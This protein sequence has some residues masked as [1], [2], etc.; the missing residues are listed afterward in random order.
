M[1]LTNSFHHTSIETRKTLDELSRIEEAIGTSRATAA[2]KRYRRRIWK[3][4]CGISTCVC[5][6][7][8]GRR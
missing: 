3:A 5:G 1:R 8:F 2:E 4:L 6:D 7:T